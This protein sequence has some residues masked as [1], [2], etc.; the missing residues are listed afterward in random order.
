MRS[1][2]SSTVGTWPD[3]VITFN[4]GPW[5]L[6]GVAP[7]AWVTLGV[8]YLANLWW[9]CGETKYKPLFWWS[10][11]ILGLICYLSVI[12]SILRVAGFSVFMF[13]FFLEKAEMSRSFSKNILLWEIVS[14]VPRFKAIRRLKWEQ[15]MKRSR[16]RTQIFGINIH[17]LL[18]R[19]AYWRVNT[20]WW[21][22]KGFI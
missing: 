3:G 21:F 17:V 1:S 4:L 11:G 20:A 18:V 10:A 5:E 2:L 14:K 15:L 22:F 8:V 6:P 7:G 16:K 12:Q 19:C 9:V 13:L